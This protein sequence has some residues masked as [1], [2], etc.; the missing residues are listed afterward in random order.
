MRFFQKVFSPGYIPDPVM[1]FQDE[2]QQCLV[3]LKL[4]QSKSDLNFFGGKR[5]MHENASSFI[6]NLSLP[7]DPLRPDPPPHEGRDDAG[8]RGRGGHGLRRGRQP[9]GRGCQGAEVQERLLG[10]ERRRCCQIV[11]DESHL[12]EQGCHQGEGA[13]E[14]GDEA[15][16]AAARGELAG[17]MEVH[18]EKNIILFHFRFVASA[19]LLQ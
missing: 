18:Q 16:A 11:E 17:K 19:L 3:L 15:K 6:R 4:P 13:E 1:H 7:L 10:R 2:F 12:D 8:G 9:Q 5:T 14:E